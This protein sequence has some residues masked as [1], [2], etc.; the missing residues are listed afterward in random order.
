MTT[1][2]KFINFFVN[3]KEYILIEKVSKFH[4][5]I[6]H[7]SCGKEFNVHYQNFYSLGSR[8]PNKE[9]VCERKKETNLKKYGVEHTFQSDKIKE[10]IKKTTL[11]RYGV[12]HNMQSKEIKERAKKTLFKNYGVYHSLQSS[13][14]MGRVNKTNKERYGTI[15]PINNKE[16]RNKV[17]KTNI[18]RYGDKV[19]LKS[20]TIREKIKETFIKN[21]GADNPFKLEKIKD[22]IKKTNLLKYGAENPFS[23]EEIK[24]KIKE[25]NFKKY[26]T[27]YAT[28]NRK[29]KEKT[30]N[31]NLKK[32]GFDNPA[33]SKKIR[34]KIIRTN[35]K[36]YGVKCT[37]SLKEV[38]DKIKKTNLERYGAE[39]YFQNK[40]FLEKNKLGNYNKLLTL[41]NCI[42]L[43]TLEEYIG[44]YKEGPV[45]YKWK[46]TKCNTEF[47]DDILVELPRCPSCF[48]LI[49]GSSFIEAEIREFIK[50]Y[51]DIECN[52]EFYYDSRKNYEID[53]FIPS[54]NIGIE[55]NGLYWHSERSGGKKRNY[56]LD[57]TKFFEKMGIQIIHIWDSEWLNKKEIVK[58]LLLSKINI[59]KDRIYARECNIKEVDSSLA[60][61]FFVNNHLQGGINSKINI[62]LF[63]NDRI[64]S[65][66]SFSKSRF[67]KNLEYEITR[68]AN[69]L[70]VTVIGGFSKLLNYFSKNYYPKSVITYADKRFSVGTLYLKNG[71]TFLRESKPNYF[72]MKNYR[73]PESREKYQKHKLKSI[74]P[75]Y[76]ESLSEWQNMKNNKYDRVWDCGNL[77]FYKDFIH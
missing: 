44:K 19:A 11:E 35:E 70:N 68:F 54:K 21:Y 77:V 51:I 45:V 53:I 25:A 4:Y 48:P 22:K 13:E 73:N 27:E 34:N 38:K 46:C 1:R 67:N 57:K 43:F 69:S 61:E 6:K 3:N 49:N 76:D 5:K 20:K 9:C 10:K 62:G 66:L 15:H 18:E 42:P 74:L 40:E 39:N 7:L 58:S 23:S 47:E 36:K 37:L 64:I 2:E 29:V 8:C 26:G 41:E 75:I 24:N 55:L 14:I 16:I 65:C 52:K 12:E 59:Y 56:H 17:E 72:Y 60:R 33:K 63:Y 32:Y 31:T 28:N 50:E 30:K 71:F